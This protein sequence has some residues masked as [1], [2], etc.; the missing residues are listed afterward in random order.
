MMIIHWYLWVD[1]VV[2]NRKGDFSEIS[3]KGSREKI[4]I[5]IAVSRFDRII[6]KF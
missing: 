6:K 3:I 5:I 2:S 4:V 1:D